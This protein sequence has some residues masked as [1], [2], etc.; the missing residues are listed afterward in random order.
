MLYAP[1]PQT[2]IFLGVASDLI[3]PKTE[4]V[5]ENALLRQQLIVLR[6]QTSRVRIPP[7][8][9][10]RVLLLARLAKSWQDA[11]LIVKPETILRWHRRGFRLF[12]KRKS[13]TKQ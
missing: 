13:K 2:S 8:D 3:R 5:A 1:R 10:V 7:M 12:W 11:V 4:L 9:R 6:R